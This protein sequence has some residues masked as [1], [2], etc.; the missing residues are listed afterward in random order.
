MRIGR[1][2]VDLDTERLEGVAVISQVAYFGRVD[3]VEIGGA[4]STTDHLPCGSASVVGMSL[5]L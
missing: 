4:K 5:P 1:H 3:K 2:R